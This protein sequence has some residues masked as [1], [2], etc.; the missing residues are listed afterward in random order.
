MNNFEFHP[1]MIPG[2]LAA[3]LII[4]LTLFKW[5]ATRD[6]EKGTVFGNFI[7]KMFDFIFAII[8]T[9]VKYLAPVIKFIFGFILLAIF[10]GFCGQFMPLKIQ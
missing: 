9:T 1:L 4:M 5:L 7:A 10:L 3:Y 8:F 2:A 6:K